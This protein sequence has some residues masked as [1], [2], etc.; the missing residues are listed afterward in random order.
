MN[1]Q[2]YI[3]ETVNIQRKYEVKYFRRISKILKS[4]VNGLIAAIKD[5]GVAAG[6][7]YLSNQ[8]TSDVAPAVKD[9]YLEVG[10]RFARRQNKLFR[11]QL[12]ST[13]AFGFNAIWTAFIQDYLFRF[14]LDKITFE[15][16]HTTR[17]VLLNVMSRGVAEGWGIDTMVEKIMNTMAEI[18]PDTGRPGI[19]RSQAARIVRTEITRASNTGA[20]A[21]GVTFEYEQQ[22]EWISASDRRVR[23]LN[24]KDHANHVSLD[25]TTIDYDDLFTDPRNGDKLRFPGDPGGN[26]IPQ[27]SAASTINCRCNIAITAKV[28]RNGRLIPRRTGTSV[29]FPSAQRRPQIITV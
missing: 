5:G 25:G 24:P 27:T 1:R 10:L 13:K 21:A 16:S 17:E 15:V 26:G 9:L 18:N 3:Q 8:L 22:K 28:D 29:I 14:L 12:K 4:E 11:E 23:G 7:R 20:M 19:L 2:T 6:N